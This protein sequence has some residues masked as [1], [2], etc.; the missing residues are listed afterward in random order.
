MIIKVLDLASRGSQ[1]G[2]VRDDQEKSQF[3]EVLT[4]F[5]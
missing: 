3:Q 1:S 4:F 2:D 5:V